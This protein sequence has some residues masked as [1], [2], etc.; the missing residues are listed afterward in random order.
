MKQGDLSAY[1][2]PEGR[3]DALGRPVYQGTIYDPLTT[4]TVEAGEVT[5]HRPYQHDGSCPAECI[6]DLVSRHSNTGSGQSHPV[7]S[8]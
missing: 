1:L 8:V 4:R 6:C 5:A 7:E 3:T 2:G